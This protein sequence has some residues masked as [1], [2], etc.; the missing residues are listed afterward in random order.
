MESLKLKV[1]KLHRDAKVP[2]KARPTDTCWDLYAVRDTR[3]PSSG[4]CA[5]VGTGI[6]LGLPKGFSA[7]ISPRSGFSEQ[8]KC[9]T[10]AGEIDNEY[11]G[12]VKVLI[13]NFS[14][15]PLVITKGTKF[16]QFKLQRIY[17]VD[18]EEVTELEQ[19]TRGDQGFGSSGQ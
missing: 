12:E 6:A 13:F 19:T 18:I 4:G 14:A 7:K 2:T 15:Y 11:T 9:T 17:S 1:K 16:A 10:G 8:Q 5:Y 3:I